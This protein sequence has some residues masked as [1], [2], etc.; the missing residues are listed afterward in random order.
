MYT[1]TPDNCTIGE[2]SRSAPE[3]GMYQFRVE[4]S[5]AASCWCVMVTVDTTTEIVG[6]NFYCSTNQ[7]TGNLLCAEQNQTTSFLSM[8]LKVGLPVYGIVKGTLENC[9]D[10]RFSTH[11]SK[12]IAIAYHNI[13]EQPMDCQNTCSMFPLI[14]VPSSTSETLM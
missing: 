10:I 2:S 9:S 6:S 1:F 5:P 4:L 7:P 12:D 3:P 14:P 11:N 8:V 13:F